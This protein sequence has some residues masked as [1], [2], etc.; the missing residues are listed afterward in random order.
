MRRTKYVVGAYR[1]YI[2]HFTLI[3]SISVNVCAI[4]CYITV[5]TIVALIQTLNTFL[6]SFVIHLLYIESTVIKTM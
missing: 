2:V 1:E 5:H 6:I 4:E 3:Q